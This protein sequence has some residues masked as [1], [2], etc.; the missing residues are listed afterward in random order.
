MTSLSINIQ[1][2]TPSK[3]PGIAKLL[4]KPGV[5][6]PSRMLHRVIDSRSLDPFHRHRRGHIAMVLNLRVV[7]HRYLELWHRHC[8]P[9]S[10]Y[11]AR[12]LKLRVVDNRCLEL[13]RR[14]QVVRRR[15]AQPRMCRESSR[16]W[17]NNGGCG[18]RISWSER[19]GMWSF[20]CAWY[21][22]RCLEGRW[23]IEDQCP[24]DPLRFWIQRHAVS[25]L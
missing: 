14:P 5:S 6:P 22:G 12:L 17:R 24:L 3:W 4:F 8:R 25:S 19:R 21:F 15:Q 9:L 13:W 2:T 11:T 10:G 18:D 20:L 23:W 7:N 1:S 16:K